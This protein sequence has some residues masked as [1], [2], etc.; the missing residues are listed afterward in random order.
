MELNSKSTHR[1][2]VPDL[3]PD[4]ADVQGPAHLGLVGQLVGNLHVEHDHNTVNKLI[5]LTLKPWRY[6]IQRKQ[7][8]ELIEATARPR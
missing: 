3:H 8:R 5:E 2:G 6:L 1:V 4:K 7:E